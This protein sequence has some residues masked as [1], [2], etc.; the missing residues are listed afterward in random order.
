MMRPD[1]NIAI[2][3]GS[4]AQSRLA[5]KLAN[6]LCEY[7]RKGYPVSVSMVKEDIKQIKKSPRQGN[8]SA[9][10]DVRIQ[11][12]MET[13]FSNFDVA[14]FLFDQKGTANI[15]YE[16]ID[17]KTHEKMINYKKC[18]TLSLNLLYEY[19]LASSMFINHELKFL[20]CFARS[21]IQIEDSLDYVKN[22][23]MRYFDEEFPDYDDDK[24]AQAII[25]QCIH[26]MP[27][28]SDENNSLEYKGVRTMFYKMDKPLPP[29]GTDIKLENPLERDANTYWPDL[30]QLKTGG[31]HVPLGTDGFSQSVDAESS[32]LGDYFEKEYKRFGKNMSI[33]E[34]E[35]SRRILYIVDRAVF[36]MYLRKETYWDE[37]AE[38]L[39]NIRSNQ[40]NTGE[41]KK[42]EI[43]PTPDAA[44]R[45]DY[46]LQTITALRGVFQYQ[47]SVRSK[48][49]FN[50]LEDI[51]K[52]LKPIVDLGDLL[53]NKMVYCLSADYLALCYHKKA[54]KMLS[55]L[56]GIDRLFL[57]DNLDDLESLHK[58][59]T[60]DSNCRDL[61]ES[62]KLFIKGVELFKTVVRCQERMQ[63]SAYNP[64]AKYIWKS[65]ALYNQARCEFIVYLIGTLYKMSCCTKN[66]V[67]GEV[68]DLISQGSNWGDN[69]QN[70]VYSRCD[71]VNLLK[72]QESFPKVILFNLNAEYF[73]A[74]FEYNLSCIVA[75]HFDANFHAEQMSNKGFDDWKNSNLTIS[76]VLDV[77]S[78]S[79]KIKR[80]NEFF[81][82]EQFNKEIQEA[83]KLISSISDI[84]KQD[85]AKLKEIL[86]K[87]NEAYSQGSYSKK[88]ANKEEWNKLNIAEKAEKVVT[89][90]AR[91]TTIATYFGITPK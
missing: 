83:I 60:S 54:T 11:K 88:K 21:R 40:L 62:I 22:I 55:E 46:Y 14:I 48:R 23:G 30:T 7:R 44:D 39:Y 27:V 15:E 25:E 86:E 16:C 19:G 38:E 89:I 18:P 20:Y 53:G 52:K 71:D 64:K 43:N 87:A 81:D 78:K 69:L 29:L 8:N 73:H 24:I 63:S 79:D 41:A 90:M 50:D 37:R 34:Y 35:L 59:L 6:K 82:K 33:S 58:H 75:K 13:Y 3:Y 5:E 68:S 74:L 10:H 42:H 84:S 61:L 85:Q 49:L 17:P 45:D 31:I 47:K 2:A 72:K 57:L 26:D 91:L 70:A 77:G 80:L 66:Q 76:D 32:A 9:S 67:D 1:I 36:I 51:I 28:Y 56:I 12:K 4:I 65:Y